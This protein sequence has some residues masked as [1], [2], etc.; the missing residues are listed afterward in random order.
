M[1]D[2]IKKHLSHFAASNWS[3]YKLGFASDVVYEEYATATRA[4]G[5]EACARAAQKWKSAFSDARG[6]MMS[7]MV[8]GDTVIAEIRWEGTHTGPLESSFGTVAPTNKRISVNA[9][10]V[11]K[12]RNGQILE[13]RHYFD[14]LTI[15]SQLGVAPPMTGATTQATLRSAAVRVSAARAAR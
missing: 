2:I 4:K 11:F 10:E 12:I 15:L 1:I 6:T 9:V 3:E 5:A 8:S 14:L 7:S 13:D